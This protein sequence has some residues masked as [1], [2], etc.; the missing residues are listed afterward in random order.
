MAKG[1]IFS[2]HE[3]GT[4]PG[5]DLVRVEL[6]RLLRSDQFKNSKRC[7]SLLT[8][9]VEETLD[10]RGEQLKERVVGVNV[11]GRNPDYE[12]AEDPVVR[13]AA[14]EV[15]KRLAQVYVESG[16]GNPVRIELHSGTYV[17][18][19][20]TIAASQENTEET[21]E[22]KRR[23]FD[24]S[25]KHPVFYSLLGV[26]TLFALVLAAWFY[27]EPGH[28][29]GASRHPP[30]PSSP[31]SEAVV[32][33]SL[34]AT[35]GDDGAVRILAGDL[36]SGSYVDRFGDRWLPDTYFTGGAAKSGPTNFVYP[37]ADPGIFRTM[38]RGNFSYDIPLRQNQLYEMRLYFVEP[39]IHYGSEVGG[40]GENSRL[41]K[42]QANGQVI[43][44]NFDVTAD[45][46]FASTTI[47]AFRNI[48][49]AS[50]GKLNLQFETER[51]EPLVAAIELLPSGGST[52]P[53]IR[54]RAAQIYAMDH[55]GNRWSPDNFYIG[56]QLYD[57]RVPVTGT[58]DSDVFKV[59]RVG[60]FYYAIPVPPGRYSLTLYF[61]E[62]YFHAPGK[63]TF[64]V[65]CNGV[66]LL[67]HFDIFQQA[68]FS[69]IS[70]KTFHGLEPN[71]Q[72]KL[73]ISFSPEVN[74]AS[75]RALEVVDE[76]R[77]H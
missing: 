25:V 50:D 37:P 16:N 24:W 69:Q 52:I 15:R 3:T 8:Y 33:P 18:E 64:D 28:R 41:F 9:I 40:D 49:A 77:G 63:R 68:G 10:G 61:A 30:S 22:V 72:G 35:A 32:A 54:I 1:A 36:Q 34:T 46:G 31:P 23:N 38:R 39:T 56:G 73:L 4:H 55:D 67:H 58:A 75:V 5:P 26:I 6:D 48:S 57:A 14:I 53:P 29:M 47:R 42:V 19:F 51:S 65:S 11:F 21:V 74:Y 7:S 60:N 44:D 27:L 59:E 12:T 43:L 66:M 20:R 62:T 2:T 71:G 70:K 13:N 76:S 17:P 45:G